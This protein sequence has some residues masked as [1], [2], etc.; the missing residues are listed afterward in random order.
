MFRQG[1]AAGRALNKASD[2]GISG[3]FNRFHGKIEAFP[4]LQF[5]E[6]NLKFRGKSGLQAAFSKSLSQNRALSAHS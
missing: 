2:I 5:W 1:I 3:I 4:K 6:S